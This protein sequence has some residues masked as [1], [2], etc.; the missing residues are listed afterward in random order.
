[1]KTVRN[2]RLLT[3]LTEKNVKDPPGLV[4]VFIAEYSTSKRK[5]LVRKV[6]Y[7]VKREFSPA[8]I[9]FLYYKSQI[10]PLADT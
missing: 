10:F 6:V 7:K 1:M 5:T 9:Q 4:K 8:E 2:H 3:K